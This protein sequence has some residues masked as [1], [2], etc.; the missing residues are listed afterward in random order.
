[1]TN[2]ETPQ[3]RAG[4]LS[5]LRILE[6]GHFIAAPFCTRV[7]GDL[8]AEIIK[9]ENPGKGD[10]VRSWGKMVDGKSLWWSVH[11]RNK[12]SVTLNMKD[13]KGLRIARQLIAECDA[14]V[15][16]F[17]PGQLARWGLGDPVIASMNPDCVVVH[18]SGYGQSGPDRDRSAFGVIGEAIGGL[19]HLTGFPEGTTPL[20]PARTGV[21][22]GD[23]VAGLYAAIG[24]L[25]AVHARRSSANTPATTVDV[26]L[27]ESVFSLLEGSLPEYGA[28]GEVR[29]PT[30]ATLPTNAPSN[31]YPTN[32][33]RWLL[34]AANSDALFSRLMTLIGRQD[35]AVD[36]RFDDNPGRVANA[37]ELDEAISIWTRSI[38]A[39]VAATMLADA[40][41]PSTLIYTIEDCANDAQFQH[42]GMIQPVEDPNFGEVLH[43]GIV[44]KFSGAEPGGVSWPGPDVGAHTDL[45]LGELL[46]LQ[47]NE[48][49]ALRAEGV[50]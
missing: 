10:P 48:L 24:L 28:L 40:D 20:P 39:D 14:V 19:R 23:M 32:D 50:V 34:I 26:A 46:G 9:V 45:V 8:G 11:G 31:A 22:L 27:T 12:K 38:A 30:G 44:P 1:M 35:L 13:P 6:L 2:A 17:R 41:I 21:S 5:G 25:S 15:E 49:Q 16:N 36:S 42:R 33:G 3:N 29:Q 7:L 43:P 4:P 18:V 47:Q 37:V